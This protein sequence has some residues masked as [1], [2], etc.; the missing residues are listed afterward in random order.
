MPST[1]R[2]KLYAIVDCDNFFVSCE[3]VFQRKLLNRPVIVLSNNDGCIVAQSP[4]VKILGIK[5]GTPIHEVKNIIKNE[6]VTV[7]SSNYTLYGDMS[8]RVMETLHEFT[9]DIDIYSIDEAFL[10]LEISDGDKYGREIR[11]AVLK[12]TG[13][14]VTIGI[15]T[16]KTLAKVAVRYCKK[17]KDRRGV[18]DLYAHPS[19]DK[20]L[21]E[22]PVND[23]W[24]IGYRTTKWLHERGIKTALDLK[25]IP[26]KM[27]RKHSGVTGLRVVYE[28]RG[29]SCVE[30][31]SMWLP[32]KSIISSRSFGRYVTSLDELKES[33]ATH[34]TIAAEKLRGDGTVAGL[35]SV[36][37][38]TNGY[39]KN[40]QYAKSAYTYI[41]PVSNASHD[42]IRCA[43]AIVKHIYRPGFKY[44][45]AGVTLFNI[46]PDTQRQLDI[47]VTRDFAREKRLYRA[48]DAINYKYGSRSIRHLACGIKQGWAMKR[49]YRSP[50]YTTNWEELPIAKIC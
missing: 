41:V 1:K 21:S 25:N 38:T 10:T 3:R 36:F 40:P 5:R 26:D 7:L 45:K 43:H 50:L 19:P 32:R 35:M 48:V 8:R 9:P 42:L 15:G 37:I 4:E 18:L 28:L 29:I 6:H 24:G 31:R 20:I 39:S 33:V 27:I 2:V 13:I 34:A 17:Q 30:L 16:T 12:H 14:P 47:F 49:N 23:V 44:I 22:V 46:T 11:T